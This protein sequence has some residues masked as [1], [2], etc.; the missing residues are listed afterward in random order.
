MLRNRTDDADLTGATATAVT[1]RSPEE[2]RPLSAEDSDQAQGAGSLPKP[3]PGRAGV[4][5]L[6]GARAR[7]GT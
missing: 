2:I 4:Q 5:S 7:V 6:P 3:R 1:T